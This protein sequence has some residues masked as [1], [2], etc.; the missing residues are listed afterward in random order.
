M[1]AENMLSADIELTETKSKLDASCKK[2]LANKIILAWIMKHS[3]EE[4][5]EFDIAEI[6]E[7]YIEGTPQIA[8]IAVHQDEADVPLI[9][10]M[11]TESVSVRE[12]T[13]TYDVRFWA[14]HPRSGEL[15][16]LIINVEAQNDFYP[17]YPLVKRGIYYGS[18]M[19]SAQYG[20]EFTNSDYGKIK[21]VYSIWICMNPP[22]YRQNT[23]SKYAMTESNMVGE[24]KEAKENYDL[25]TIIMICLGDSEKVEADLLKMLN[26]LFSEEKSAQEKKNILEKNFDIKMT[27]KLEKEMMQMCNY[28]DGVLE[29]GIEQ[30]I[31]RGI[32]QGIE[33]GMERGMQSGIENSIRNLM[34]SMKLTVGQAMEALKVPEEEREGYRS[35][36]EK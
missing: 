1:E 25:M 27:K 32:E 18:R 21:K 28:S 2:V 10:G 36:I 24:V 23:I 3:M 5:Q 15:I 29:R 31:E 34:E 22:Q 16:R 33:Q 20:T 11:S 35:R 12:G 7:K 19:I 6:A 13:V 14:V 9:N 4:F 30:G 8:N 17:G 26:V